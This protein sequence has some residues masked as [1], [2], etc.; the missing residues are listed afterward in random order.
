MGGIVGQIATEHDLD[1]EDDITFTGPESLSIQESI[2]AV[3]R[4]SRNEGHIVA[5]RN[6]VGGIAGKADFGAIVSCES[7]PCRREK[8]NAHGNG[9][10]Y[11][12]YHGGLCP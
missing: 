2:K 11:R 7:W 9:C 3:V 4:E 5:K 8:R 10:R 1:P 6:Y 12:L